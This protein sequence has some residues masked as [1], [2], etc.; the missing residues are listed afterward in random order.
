VIAVYSPATNSWRVSRTLSSLLGGTDVPGD[1]DTGVY[2]GGLIGKQVMLLRQV[3]DELYTYSYDLAAGT[4]RQRAYAL[5]PART[6]GVMVTAAAAGRLV[7]WWYGDGGPINVHTISPG[8]AWRTAAWPAGVTGFRVLQSAG[9]GGILLTRPVARSEPRGT[10]FEATELYLVDPVT[11]RVRSLGLAPSERYSDLF[12]EWTGS[13]LIALEPIPPWTSGNFG[14]PEQYL[15]S[16]AIWALDSAAGHW[17]HLPP[18]KVVSP[19][20]W[21]GP[22]LG[23]RQLFVA[24]G[25]RV[26]SLV[27]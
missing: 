1:G 4:W 11:L 14:T 9:G 21:L 27:P 22:I 15:A 20:F 17:Y 25:D 3:R 7:V 8:G 19:F 6:D 5:T 12:A 16:Y 23:G 18:G 10:S 24:S 26:W 13:A 2:V